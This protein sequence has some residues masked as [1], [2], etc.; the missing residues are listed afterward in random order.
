MPKQLTTSII[1]CGDNLQ[2][3]KEIPDES[4]DLIY[5]D[6]PFNSNRN[7]EVFW[8]DIQEKRAF[9]DRFGDAEAYIRYMR[10]R[11]LEL[12]RVLKKNGS[13]YYH[14]D[15][16]ASHYVKLML[17]QIFDFNNFQNEIIWWYR[18]GGV[19]KKR[20][21]RRHDSIFFYTRG[22][23]W[24]FNVDEVRTPYS[25]ESLERLKY[26]ARAFRGDKV[27]DKYE[28]N[29]LGKHPDDVWDIQ[30][31]MPSEKERLGYPTQKPVR[32]LERIVKVSSKEGDVVLDAFCGCGTTLVAAQKLGR[33]WIG[34][35]ISPTACRVMAQ[36]LTDGFRLV[37]G[38]DFILSDLPKSEEELMK[39]PH[40][41]FQNWAVIALGGIPNRIKVGDYGIDGKLYPIEQERVKSDEK[42]LFGDI[43][44]YYPIQVKQKD[45]A[46]R[47]DIDNFE[48]AM[49]RDK[50]KRGYFISFGFTGDAIEEIKRLDKEGELEIVPITVNDLLQKKS[51]TQ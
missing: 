50:R 19:S 33:K 25:K 21:G 13:F 1:Y 8:G 15:W 10:P 49:R 42:G 43:D 14:C 7:Y 28:A 46:G 16:H 18:G 17:D 39:L 2:M 47:P 48:T 4:V 40:F 26:K 34:I 27:Y 22:K 3:L 24:I 37:E 45:K 9:E 5:I 11:V 30:P 51:L 35:D 31:L 23:G 41:E 38:K 20:F 36:R 12:Y 29:P 44:I 32:L 6:P